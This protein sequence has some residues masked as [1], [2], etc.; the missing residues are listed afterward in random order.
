MASAGVSSSSSASSASSAL[1]MSRT[2]NASARL[3]SVPPA[4]SA[5]TCAGTPF[6]SS[7]IAAIRAD[8]SSAY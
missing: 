7:T 8:I 2:G 6:A 3:G 4:V 5:D 1:T